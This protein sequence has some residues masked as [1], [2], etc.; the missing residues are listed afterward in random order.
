MLRSSE[1]DSGVSTSVDSL[2]ILLT[3]YTGVCNV[4]PW[5]SRS[6]HVL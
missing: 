5:R 6:Y 4:A 2:T 3:F 1:G